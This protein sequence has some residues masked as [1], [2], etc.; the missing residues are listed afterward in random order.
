MFGRPQTYKPSFWARLFQ[1]EKWK[2]NLNPSVPD[3]IRLFSEGGADLLCLEIT[4]IATSKALLWHSVEIRSKDRTDRLSGLNADAAS[5]LE[6]VLQVFINNYLSLLIINDKDQLVKIDMRIRQMTHECRQYLAKADIVKVI[7]EMPG[8]ASLALSHPLFNSELMQKSV[9]GH[10]SQSLAILTDKAVRNDY[11]EKFVKAELERFETFFDDLGGFC[12]SLEQREAC[13]RLEDNNLL[14]ASAGSGKSATMVGKVAYALEKQLYRP[15]EILVLAFNRSAVDELKERIGK[16]LGVEKDKLDCKVMTFHSLGRS[17]IESTTG[18]PPNLANWIEHPVGEARVMEQLINR[19][20]E[21]DEEFARTWINLLT[22]FPKADLPEASFDT[23]DDY[24]RYIADRNANDSGIVGTIAGV[25]VRSLQE[26]RIV[27]WLWRHS[28]EFKYEK[29]LTV[30]D[31]DLKVRNIQP[32]FYYPLTGTYHEHFAINADGSSPFKNYVVHTQSKREAYRHEGLDIFETTSAQS[33]DG[34]LLT[35]LETELRKRQIPFKERSDEE[36]L[37]ALEPMVIKHYHK[38]ISICIKHIRSNKLTLDMLLERAK[39][40]HDK[41]RAKLFAEVVWKIAAAYSRKLEDEGCIDFDAM[42]GDAVKLVESGK[43]HSPFSLILVDE[44]QDI[45]DPRANLIKSLKHQNPFSKFFAVGDDWQSIYRF[46][47]SD[48]TIFTQFEKNFGT[49]WRGMLEQ[50]YRCN[51]L[52]ADTAADFIQKNP[53]QI[54]KTV[55]STRP[56]IARSIR[57]IPIKQEWQKRS[58]DDACFKL[59]ARLDSFL[60]GIASRW[61]DDDC[62]KLKVLVLW[63]YNH[64]NPFKNSRPNFANIEVSGLSFHRSKG[65]EADYSIILDVSEGDYGVPSRIEDDELLNLV[66]PRPETFSYAEERRLFYVAMTR[67]SR[68]TFLLTNEKKPSRYIGELRN[69]S[70]EDIRFETIEGEE[71]DQCP[72]C[73]VGQM[74]PRRSKGGLDFRGCSAFPSCRNTAPRLERAEAKPPPQEV[75]AVRP[76]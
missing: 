42:I 5:Q 44:F 63:R 21:E 36:I 10:L 24:H 12:L 17:I 67:A 22:V 35:H 26:Q 31:S 54:K 25:F 55:R 18:N 13:I 58:F 28:V 68:G 71:L 11:N 74:V 64:L 4:S 39:A 19:L 14:V 3:R 72:E 66:I 61:R 47:G 15:E 37:D 6:K 16:E 69:I 7:A 48:I 8:E 46:A 70:G 41:S 56:A 52:L 29:Q 59:L 60:E 30:H 73:L 38:L 49:S 51:Q 33:D 40:L 53:E 20:M 34:T 57:V 50:T 76:N 9:Q 45:S 2:L 43:F 23:S 75:S 65:L 27:N 1:V 62:K 32:D